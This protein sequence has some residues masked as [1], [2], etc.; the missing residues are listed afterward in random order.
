MDTSLNNQSIPKHKLVFLGD[1][2]VG[3][4]SIINR[5]LNNSYDTVY[6]ATIGIDFLSKI[7]SVDN[8]SIK[9][10]LWDTAGQ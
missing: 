4:T 2:F 8:K 5:F 3:K 7:Y 9:L 6:Q 10:Q 1:Q